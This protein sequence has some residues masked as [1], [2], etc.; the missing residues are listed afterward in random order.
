MKK[1]HYKVFL[2]ICSILSVAA[3]FLPVI[4]MQDG[5]LGIKGTGLSIVDFMGGNFKTS[6]ITAVT[7]D[8]RMIQL[9]QV[10]LIAVMAIQFIA[11]LSA[12]KGK[13]M[14]FAYFVASLLSIF[15]GAYIWYSC[16]KTASGYGGFLVITADV[17]TYILFL[18]GILELFFLVKWGFLREKSY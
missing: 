3:L 17:G 4:R 12:F 10:L 2:V 11:G 14:P 16:F 15:T 6:I 8:Y 7:F 1:I 5:I 13:I 18:I 9:T